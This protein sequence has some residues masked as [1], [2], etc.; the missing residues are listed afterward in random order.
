MISLNSI[1]YGNNLFDAF[2][3]LK[4]NYD[5]N[6]EHP[7]YFHPCGLICFVGP[8]GSGKTLSAVNYVRNLIKYYPKVKVVSN[9]DLTFL[10]DDDELYAYFIDADDFFKHKNGE[11]GVIFLIDE[12]QLYFNSLQSKNINID[13]IN[14]ISQQRKQR[15]HIVATSQV[16]GR[17]AKPLRE[18]FDAVILCKKYFNCIERLMLIDRDSMDDDASTGTNIQAKVKR[19]FWCF[20][21]PN[22]YEWYDTYKVIN[23]HEKDFAY[24]E[25][26]EDDVYGLRYST[27]SKPSK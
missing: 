16:F 6:K 12:I 15:V 24:G 9:L 25:E 14:F 5:F 11:E 8:Q 7:N 10:E 19:N 3:T 2:N 13:V 18:Q 4:Y 20:H 17:M 26:R 27:N 21:K 1:K 22:M 23:E